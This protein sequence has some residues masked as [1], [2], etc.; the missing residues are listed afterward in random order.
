MRVLLASLIL[1]TVPMAMAAPAEPVL[2]AVQ[3]SAGS[4]S[5]ADLQSVQQ[6]IRRQLDAFLADDGEAA[7]GL[8][9]PGIQGLFGSP[10]RFMS[11]VR[12]AYPQV[13]R[14]RE[15]EFR[16]IVEMNGRPTQRV[17]LVGPDGIP[18]IALYPMERQPD[19]SW[20]IDGCMLARSGELTA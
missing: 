4:V 2:P 19:G 20:R 11:M 16:D 5:E 13:Y 8:A 12:E 7:F 17:L 3:V 1:G 15:A 10:Q 6:V 9:S 18:V 14:A